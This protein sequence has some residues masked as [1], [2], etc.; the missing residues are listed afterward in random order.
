MNVA[1]TV[2]VGLLAKFLA[3]LAEHLAEWLLHRV[4]EEVEARKEFVEEVWDFVS[5]FFKSFA[6][7]LCGRSRNL[8]HEEEGW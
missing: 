6:G 1:I 4:S 5:W 8:F 2:G 3:M 7:G